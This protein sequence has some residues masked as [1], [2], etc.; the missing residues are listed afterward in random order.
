MS[1]PG[2]GLGWRMQSFERLALTQVHVNTA[3]QARIEAAH[4]THDVDAL[5][6]LPVVLF[7]DRL[8]LYGI[9]VRAGGAVAVT[10]VRVPRRRRGRG[11]G[12]D[13]SGADHHVVAQPAAD[14]L[15]EAAA[16][17]L[18]GHLELLPR[19]GAAGPDLRQRLL[20]EVQRARRRV[21]L[22]GRPCAVALGRVAAV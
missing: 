14:S 1:I 4:R 10:R 13:L 11:G 12:R 5:E 7:E 2:H 15:S 6:I 18:V 21:G 22:E 3:R 19:L 16:D 9:L 17:A 20:S 8:A